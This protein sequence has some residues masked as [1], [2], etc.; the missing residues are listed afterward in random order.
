MAEQ[1]H[2]IT[3]E[4]R[5]QAFDQAIARL[6]AVT[7]DLAD[8][9]RAIATVLENS[10]RQNFEE[11]GRPNKWQES[12]RAREQGG[13]TL[14]DTDRLYN[15]ITAAFDAANN[16]VR[17]GTN[18]VY[19]PAHHFGAHQTVVQH[20]REHVAIRNQAFGRPMTPRPVTVRAHDRTM[21]LK[22]PARPFMMIQSE[23]WETIG[24]IVQAAIDEA[25]RS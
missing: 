21:P 13:Q 25:V 18:V 15:S 10:V 1:T 14:R 24:D 9:G 4:L 12:K 6:R 2:G 20:V 17:V 19:A 8:A 22:L 7:D 3:L 5:H 16:Q 23:D 11:G